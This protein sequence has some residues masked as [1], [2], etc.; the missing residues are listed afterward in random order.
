M[1]CA[2]VGCHSKRARCF[3]CA[4]SFLG[5]SKSI[6]WGVEQ[7]NQAQQMEYIY[8]ARACECACVNICLIAYFGSF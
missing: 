5:I 1:H 2:I 8:S 6:E 7:P 4:Q 3:S